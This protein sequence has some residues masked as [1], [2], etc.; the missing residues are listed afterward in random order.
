MDE[1]LAPVAAS[2]ANPNRLARRREVQRAKRALP[3]VF[4][5]LNVAT[6]QIFGAMVL[7]HCY[8]SSED[9]VDVL[10]TVSRVA[11]L[12]AY[13]ELQP[14]ESKYKSN[15]FQLLPDIEQSIRTSASR[16]GGL[17][18]HHFAEFAAGIWKTNL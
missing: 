13:H 17:L 11:L 5:M 16:S 7:S 1:L 12:E 8:A 4:L 3:L 14:S 2:S 15:I 18:C 9:P 6:H 10:W